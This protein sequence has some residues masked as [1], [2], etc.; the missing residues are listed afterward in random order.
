M[1]QARIYNTAGK[2]TQY[3][4]Y[5]CGGLVGSYVPLSSVSSIEI[6]ADCCSRP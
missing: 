3:C 5:Y 1:L 4:K 6:T 2:N